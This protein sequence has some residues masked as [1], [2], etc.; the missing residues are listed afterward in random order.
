M[1]KLYLLQLYCNSSNKIFF[2]RVQKS[3][4]Y[5]SVV[6]VVS[7]AVVSAVVSAVVDAVVGPVVGAA[8]G[9]VVCAVVGVVDTT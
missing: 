6:D 4:S 1:Q 7:G 3:T 2:T 9:T 8:F 5:S